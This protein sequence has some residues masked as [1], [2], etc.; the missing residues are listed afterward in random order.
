MTESDEFG[1]NNEMLNLVDISEDD[2]PDETEVDRSQ[3]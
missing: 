1:I 2:E 3:E